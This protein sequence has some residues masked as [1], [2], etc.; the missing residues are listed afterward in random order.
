MTVDALFRGGAVNPSAT[1]SGVE[2]NRPDL[3][4]WLHTGR[5]TLVDEGKQSVSAAAWSELP[6]QVQA[7]ALEDFDR[8]VRGRAKA[9][10]LFLRP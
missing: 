9:A 6:P 10:V 3:M 8:V 4:E 7:N 5:L 2:Q 1:L